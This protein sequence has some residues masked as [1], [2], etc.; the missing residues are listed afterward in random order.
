MWINNFTGEV[1]NSLRH[2]VVTVIRDM[3]RYPAC[4]T[5]KMLDISKFTPATE[6][7]V[8]WWEPGC[9]DINKAPVVDPDET[10][11]PDEIEIKLPFE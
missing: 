10:W 1:Y 4:R 5:I 7:M 6:Q 11:I 2:A 8:R 9:K 3:I